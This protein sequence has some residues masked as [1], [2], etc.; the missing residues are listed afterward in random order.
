MRKKAF[1][2]AKKSNF[3]RNFIDPIIIILF[4]VTQLLLLIKIQISSLTISNKRRR[5]MHKVS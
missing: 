2:C 4:L 5:E 1:L 3:K